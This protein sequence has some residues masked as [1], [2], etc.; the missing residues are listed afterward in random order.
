[1]WADR[2]EVPKGSA[3]IFFRKVKFWNDDEAEEAPPVFV[4]ICYLLPLSC[5]DCKLWAT[6]VDNL[7]AVTV[8]LASC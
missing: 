8:I 3:E 2:G 4:R 6:S 5:S 7:A 1:M